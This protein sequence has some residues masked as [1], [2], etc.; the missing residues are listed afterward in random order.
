MEKSLALLAAEV[1]GFIAQDEAHGG[2]EV[3]LARAIAANDDVTFGREG[4]DLHLVLVA[5]VT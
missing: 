4:L 1:E 2:E 3:A 5:V